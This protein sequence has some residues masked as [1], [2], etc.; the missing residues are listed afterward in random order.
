MKRG[1]SAGLT[2]GALAFGAGMSY[3]YNS[4]TTGLIMTEREQRKQYAAKAEDVGMISRLS[5]DAVANAAGG[6]RDLGATGELVFGLNAA[7]RGRQ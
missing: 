3:L 7:R 2:L 5:Y 6:T 1:L 4:S